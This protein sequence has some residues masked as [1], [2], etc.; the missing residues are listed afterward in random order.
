MVESNSG[1]AQEFDLTFAKADRPAGLVVKG[2][3][4]GQLEI[5]FSM[6]NVPLP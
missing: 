1:Y 3:K 2:N 5:P 4:P 6:K